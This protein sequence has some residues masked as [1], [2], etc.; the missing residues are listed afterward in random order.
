MHWWRIYAQVAVRLSSA[1]SYC[2]INASETHIML[3]VFMYLYI[4]L[5]K[6]HYSCL[7]LMVN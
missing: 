5:S 7:L 4:H 1:Q 3:Q 6:N 2:T